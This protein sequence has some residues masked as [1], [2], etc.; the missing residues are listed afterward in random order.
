[1]EWTKD[2]PTKPGWY[3]IVPLRDDDLSGR[4]P[5]Y[6]VLVEQEGPRF[7]R[8]WVPGMDYADPVESIAGAYWFGPIE[9]PALPN[10]IEAN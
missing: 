1:M 7:F 3:W 4:T 10:I 2:L 9:P 6:A 5:P 8:Y